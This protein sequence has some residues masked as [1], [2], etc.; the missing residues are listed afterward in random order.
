M[1]N[2][3]DTILVVDDDV[4]FSM[5]IAQFLRKAGY[6]MTS[7]HNIKEAMACLQQHTYALLLLDYRLP[8]GTGLELMVKAQEMGHKV[9]A[10]IMTSFH[11]VRTAVQA[12]RSGAIDYI[13]KPVNRDELLMQVQQ[14]L[15]PASSANSANPSYVE[16]QSPLAQKLHQQI[17]LIA[18]TDMSVI[19]QGESGTGKEHVA[20]LIHN[21]SE[22]CHKPFVAVDCGTLSTELAASELFG[23]L[24]G[25]F[26]G[27]LQDKK[28]KFEVANGG[29]IFL[30]EIGNL[31][32]DVQIKLLRALQERMIAPIGSN[33]ETK[34]DVRI[35]VATN[36]DLKNSVA[37]GRFRED[38]YHRLN[39]FKIQVPPLRARGVDLKLFVHHFIEEANQSLKRSVQGLTSAVWQVLESYDWPGNIRELRNIVKRLVLLT[40]GSLADVDALPEEMMDG[41]KTIGPAIHNL[42]ADLKRWQA[43]HEKALIEETLKAVHYNKKQAAK[44]LNIN[45]STLYA[46]IDK[47]GIKD[48]P[49]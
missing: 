49:D 45:R 22:R 15:Q 19:I 40:P 26:T 31:T 7:A 4:T 1:V 27:A 28:G 2:K 9:P 17:Q 8:D 34:I 13:T 39:E 20:R 43:N 23:H 32:Y 11:D 30:D 14:L 29:T 33:K 37:E 6:T 10:I 18:P 21:Q 48:K 46:K 25:A 42:D 35:I 47:Y 38:L 44:R 3:T 24:K 16:G 12:M 5:I 41:T 36:E